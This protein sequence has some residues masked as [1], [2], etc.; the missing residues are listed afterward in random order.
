MVCRGIRNLVLEQAA[1]GEPRLA[2][3]YQLGER[4]GASRMTVRAALRRIEVEGML[5]RRQGDG[6]YVHD[7]FL[8]HVSE[9]SSAARTSAVVPEAVS[10]G[11][12]T[13]ELGSFEYP[14]ANRAFW[15]DIL[16]S[17]QNHHPGT[18]IHARLMM[19]TEATEAHGLSDLPDV[20]NVAAQDIPGLA[21][22]GLLLPLDAVAAGHPLLDQLDPASLDACRYNGRLYGLPQEIGLAIMYYN[23]T[24]LDRLGTHVPATWDDM[25]GL[26]RV[27]SSRLPMGTG[28]VNYLATCPLLVH[29]GVFPPDRIPSWDVYRQ[30]PARRFLEWIKDMTAIPGALVEIQQGGSSGLPEFLAGEMV[31]LVQGSNVNTHIHRYQSFPVCLAPF[32]MAVGATRENTVV[33]WAIRRNSHVSLAAWHW[34]EHILS[35]TAQAALA[36]KY[37]NLPANGDAAVR[38]TY[39]DADVSGIDVVPEGIAEGKLHTMPTDLQSSLETEVWRPAVNALAKRQCTVSETLA[40]MEEGHRKV[41][42]L[43]E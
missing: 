33:A 31:F 2:S 21:D 23:R 26:A 11:S 39:R 43:R 35:P 16:K 22:R 18:E 42:L 6:T 20:F 1:R 38:Q 9:M 27:L 37:G 4:F 30:K 15:D 41:L 3:E 7:D 10:A 14:N 24:L 19:P 25:L 29:F 40:A 12:A 28:L 17:F 8:D 32:P 36:G 13:I 34:I 5:V